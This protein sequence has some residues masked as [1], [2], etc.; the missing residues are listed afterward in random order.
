MEAPS[1]VMFKSENAGDYFADIF[2]QENVL[3]EIKVAKQYIAARVA[4]L[5]NELKATRIEVGLLI[6]FGKQKLELKSLVMR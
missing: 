5:L 6:N 3:V 1:E 4:Q 2:V